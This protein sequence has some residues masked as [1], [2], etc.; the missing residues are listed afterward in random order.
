[1]NLRYTA[2]Q[3]IIKSSAGNEVGK[4][5]AMYAFC[6]NGLISVAKGAGYMLS[7]SPS[8]FGEMIH[9]IADTANQGFL[10]IGIHKSK[11]KADAD[12]AY[13]YGSERF[14][15]AL[16]SACGIFF[17]GA[18]VTAYH[19]IMSLTA[20]AQI[21]L[22]PII[23]FILAFSFLVESITLYKA[24]R[25]IKYQMHINDADDFFEYL[26]DADPVLS[27]ILYEDTVAVLG[28]VTAFIGISLSYMTGN[29][30]Y[31]SLA[32]LV[33]AAMLGV[34]AVVLINKNRK[35]LLGKSIPED[36]R[37][38]IIEMLEEDMHIDKVLEFK[39]EI[40]NIGHY[41]IKCEIEFNG[42]S[43]LS[44]IMQHESLQKE[45]EDM[46][47]EYEEFKKYIIYHTSR[48]PR[49][50]GKRIDEIEAKIKAK[51]PQIAYIDLEIN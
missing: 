33:I 45:W 28:V 30:V 15:W 31:D 50:M 37:L 48:I 29:H 42:S 21:E 10:L 8:L 22:K 17:V 19:G 43:L 14:F 20:H 6:G 24:Y 44:E 18:G 2:N 47:G 36:V 41:H 16:L 9:S 5:S 1:M 25:E 23:L 34:I 3:E 40:L 4:V 32:S 26:K 51:Y 39:S 7:G 49:I 12:F 13:G 38:E 46:D 11:K 27:A 35:F